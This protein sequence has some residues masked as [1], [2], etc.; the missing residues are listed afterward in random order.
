MAEELIKGTT[1]VYG[2][3][4]VTPMEVEVRVWTE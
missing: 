2:V 4:P 1:V 3:P